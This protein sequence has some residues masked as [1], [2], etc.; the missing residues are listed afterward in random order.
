MNRRVVTIIDTDVAGGSSVGLVAMIEVAALMIG[1]IVQCYSRTRYDD[2][3]AI[4]TGMFLEKGSP[5][6][7]Y[8]PGS[9]TDI[10]VFQ[11]KR[12]D[13][14][15]DI[16]SNLSDHRVSNRFSNW[17]GGAFAETEVKVRSLIG[18]RKKKTGGRGFPN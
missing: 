17:F 16:V 18:K 15:G 14:A 13:F 10:L 7:L 8:R 1:D 6:S 2:P 12:V 4:Q 5:K 9:S 11:K 3:V